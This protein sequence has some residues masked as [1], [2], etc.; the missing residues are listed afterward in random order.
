[1]L[2]T[3]AHLRRKAR[4]EDGAHGFAVVQSLLWRMA[5]SLPRASAMA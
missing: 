3:N 4:A 1:M 2:R 5:Q